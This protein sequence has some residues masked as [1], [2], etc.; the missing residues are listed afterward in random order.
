MT[1][2]TVLSQVPSA[3]RVADD[4]RM[5]QAESRIIRDGMSIPPIRLTEL[6]A[7]LMVLQG[8]TGA[9]AARIQAIPGMY[10]PPNWKPFAAESRPGLSNRID[11]L[12]SAA[13]SVD[14]TNSD[15]ERA[16]LAEPLRA[17]L[18]TGAAVDPGPAKACS[19][20]TTMLGAWAGEQG[21]LGRWRSTATKRAVG[22][23]Q[24]GSL[25]RWLDLLN[26]IEPLRSAGLTDARAMVLS[27]QLEPDDARRSFELGLAQNSVDERLKNTGL[28]AFDVSAHERSIARF[29]TA[30]GAARAHLTTV[31]PQQVE[32]ARTF[33]SAAAG[34]QVG[35][36][37]RQLTMRRGGMKVRDLMS[38]YGELITQVLPCVLVSPD[39]LA[40]FFPAT[41]G[42]FDI[43]VFD[44]PRR[45]ESRMQL[46]RW[47]EDG[48]L[49]SWVT[50]SRCHRRRLPK[51]PSPGMTS[52]RTPLETRSKTRSQF[53]PN[54][55]KFG[56][57]A[58]PH[59]ALP[60]PGR[61]AHRV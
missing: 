26:L 50:A 35:Q 30:S 52:S 31:L 34:E 3:P 51:V 59:L 32:C 40:R 56:G 7:S 13:S 58:S 45:C 60:K 29:G 19:V 47:A 15:P 39:S 27:G 12:R 57:T 54:V 49:S 36:L 23:P 55:F 6:T 10:V 8:A 11:Q 61:V 42:L 33:N 22:D 17:A 4:N 16:R 5:A 21:L 38:T 18:Q 2:S 25:R 53:S 41:A 20:S 48:P 44:E 46:A 14:P 43:V 37:R 1:K 28:A 9:L 24:L